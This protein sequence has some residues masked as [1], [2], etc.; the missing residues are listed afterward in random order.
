MPTPPAQTWVYLDGH[1]LPGEQAQISIFDRGFL[2]GD[3]VFEVL[4]THGKH[5]LFWPLHSQ[6]L[7]QS[8]AILSIPCPPLSELQAASQQLLAHLPDAPPAWVLRLMLTRGLSSLDLSPAADAQPTLLLIASPLRPLDPAL[9]QH[10][11]VLALAPQHR[12]DLMPGA[13]S[14]NYLP[15]IL[16]TA[17]ARAHGAHE[18][19][20]LTPDGSLAEGATSNVFFVRDN[21]LHTPALHL[22]ILPGITRQLVLTLAAQAGLASEQGTYSLPDLLH[23]DEA[24]VTSSLRGVLPIV[25]LADTQ[26]AAGVPGPLTK[27]LM[28][29]YRL[30]QG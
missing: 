11:A 17:H 15:S 5:P 4:R 21:V 29:A 10:G 30:L 12:T 14:G 7:A 9:Y 23:A 27:R 1:V 6:R 13:K 22:G 16:A 28:H 25:R 20:L 8:A 2:Y 18:A 24:F 3:S 19:L 26:I